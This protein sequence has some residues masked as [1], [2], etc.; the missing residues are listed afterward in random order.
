MAGKAKKAPS[1]FMNPVEPSSELAEIVGSDPMPR[2]EIT[3]R[4]WDYIKKNN[5]QNPKNKR[6]IVPDTKLAAV[7]GGKA[8]VDMFEMTRKVSKHLSTPASV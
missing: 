4:L 2:T 5:L 3:K 6:E 8:A 1:A 7:F